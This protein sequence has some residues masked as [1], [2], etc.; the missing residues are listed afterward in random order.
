MSTENIPPINKNEGHP[1]IKLK[2]LTENEAKEYFNLI[3][4]NREHF[5]N[6]GNF[7]VN[8]Y[9]SVEE[10]KLALKN[11]NNKERWGIYKEN[12]LTGL[13]SLAPQKEARIAKIGL[14][15]AK[16][17]SGQGIA[18]KAV[19]DLANSDSVKEKFDF[20]VANVH[21]HNIA[22]QRVLEKSGFQRIEEGTIKDNK[23]HYKK[24]LWP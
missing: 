13:I 21:I 20:F 2:Q 24:E 5:A 19:F 8:K 14:L 17:S 1:E 18:T 3:N 9:K 6:F 12:T 22:S 23:Y 4:E 15:V 11:S 7:D 10:V 16:K